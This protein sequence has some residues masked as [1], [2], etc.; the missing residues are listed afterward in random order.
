MTL[1]TVVNGL[2]VSTMLLGP[3]LSL[4]ASAQ[5][6][7]PGFSGQGKSSVAGCPNLQWRIARHDDGTAAGIAWYSDLSGVSQIKGSSDA[8]GEFHLQLTSLQGKGP[9]GTVVGHRAPDGGLVADLTG[10]GCANMHFTVA[11]VPSSNS[12]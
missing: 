3:V 10:E 12:F 9:V 8:A 4:S 7:G 5:T 11:G 6:S 1:M 2:A